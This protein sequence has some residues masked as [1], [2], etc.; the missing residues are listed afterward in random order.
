MFPFNSH[1]YVD[2][3]VSRFPMIQAGSQSV[4]GMENS[5][6]RLIRF[7]VH[8]VDSLLLPHVMKT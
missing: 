6:A 3:A 5:L 2:S 4:S 7:L 1:D 8:K